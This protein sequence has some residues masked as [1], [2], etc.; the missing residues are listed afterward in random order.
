MRP[1]S[2]PR[3]LSYNRISESVISLVLIPCRNER[4]LQ[5]LPYNRPWRTFHRTYLST[6]LLS[7]TSASGV[8]VCAS[9]GGRTAADSLLGRSSLRGTLVGSGV[10]GPGIAPPEWLSHCKGIELGH[11]CALRASHNCC[12]TVSSLLS[13]LLGHCTPESHGT[14]AVAAHGRDVSCRFQRGQV[15]RPGPICATRQLGRCCCVRHSTLGGCVCG[16]MA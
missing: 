1:E 14:R 16:S 6:H 2:F 12:P 7:R 11:R 4:A 10:V 5:L 13:L 8:C 9:R 3:L 15:V